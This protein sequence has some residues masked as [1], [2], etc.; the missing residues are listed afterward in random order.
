M[1]S[2]HE[3]LPHIIGVGPQWATT[4][5]RQ[6]A[7]VVFCE[8][9]GSRSNKRL[10]YEPRDLEYNALTDWQPVQLPCHWCDVV[11]PT[12]ACDQAGGS[13]LHRLQ[14]STPSGT[15]PSNIWS[16]GDEV[17]YIPSKVCQVCAVKRHSR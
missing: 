17:S 11:T 3:Q 12:G 2:R 9:R 15:S 1:C 14:A 5:V 4:N 16:I 10:M 6:K 8:V 7:T 13:V